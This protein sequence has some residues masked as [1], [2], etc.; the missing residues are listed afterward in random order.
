MLSGPLLCAVGGS[1]GELRVFCKQQSGFIEIFHHNQYDPSG[2][3]SKNVCCLFL[4]TNE[5][6]IS[7]RKSRLDNSSTE[8]SSTTR[9]G[10]LARMRSTR[11]SSNMNNTEPVVADGYLAVGSRSGVVECWDVAKQECIF[12]TTLGHAD[13]HVGRVNALTLLMNS[14]S[15]L[16][17][18]LLSGGND[19]TARLYDIRSKRCALVIDSASG[20]VTS[21]AGGSGDLSTCLLFIG[22]A[23]G[24]IRS[25]SFRNGEAV[26]LIRIYRGHSDRVVSIETFVE[27]NETMLRTFS[28]DGTVR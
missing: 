1:K 11:S 3:S 13:G 15:R 18:L 27:S 7:V 25:Y 23:D 26:R 14:S 22:S 2:N 5:K 19:R 16:P 4:A 12:S 10:M 21:V 24:V 6:R 9:S 17:P 28:R 20:P 8:G